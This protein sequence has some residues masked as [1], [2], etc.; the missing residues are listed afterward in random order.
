MRAAFSSHRT[1]PFPPG[2]ICLGARRRDAPFPSLQ[3]TSRRIEARARDDELVPVAYFVGDGVQRHLDAIFH[4]LGIQR[5]GAIADMCQ[6]PRDAR[7][8]R[9]SV[10]RR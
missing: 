9:L 4:R 8:F 10:R 5:S 3:P 2:M 1:L 6:H 7:E